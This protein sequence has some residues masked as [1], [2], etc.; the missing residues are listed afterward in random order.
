MVGRRGNTG[1]DTP[2]FRE[3]PVTHTEV[4]FVTTSYQTNPLQQ[5]AETFLS[6]GWSVFPVRHKKPAVGWKR[7]QTQRGTLGELFDRTDFDGIGCVTGPV[8]GGLCV[9]DFDEVAAYNQWAEKHPRLARELPTV[10]TSRGYHVYFRT[11]RPVYAKFEDGE[12]IGDSLHYVVLPPSAHPSGA[13]YEW[14]VEPRGLSD[15]PTLDPVSAGFLPPERKKREIDVDP[16]TE[17]KAVRRS[18]GFVVF[19]KAEKTTD[20]QLLEAA[21]RCQPYETGQRNQK[22]F[23]F[24]RALK[25]LVPDDAPWTTLSQALHTWWNLA[26]RVVATQDYAQTERDFRLAWKSAKVPM[27]Q[28]LAFEVKADSPLLPEAV[29]GGKRDR[30]DTA[31]ERLVRVCQS[32]GQQ[33]LFYLSRRTAGRLIG[34]SDVT[35]ASLLRQFVASGFL[36]IVEQGLPHPTRRR[37]TRY[38]LGGPDVQ[39]RDEDGIRTHS[40]VPGPRRPDR[41]PDGPDQGVRD[42]AVEPRAGRAAGTAPEA[43]PD[44]SAVTTNQEKPSVVVCPLP[45]PGPELVAAEP[46]PTPTR[47]DVNTFLPYPDY[48]RSA[49]CLDWRRLGKQRVECLQMVNCI[50]NNLKPWSNHPCTRMWRPYVQALIEYGVVVCDVWIGRGYNDTCRDK[51]LAFRSGEV[52]TPPW[53]GSPKLHASHRG[54][55]TRKDPAHYS[56]YWSDAPMDTTQYFWPDPKYFWPDH[57]PHPMVLAEDFP[58][59]MSMR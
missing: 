45:T 28:S 43:V 2:V 59:L 10:R 19:S 32:M 36:E 37:A 34:V 22:L 14:V 11:E 16:L 35:A 49:V 8:S 6:W 52:I 31:R 27:S 20:R 53:L 56:Q 25:D 33:G 39:G 9:R 29:L 50:A 4:P 13:V 3:T 42:Q 51:L 1:A 57:E 23:K 40:G 47:P 17:R 46:R 5:E 41:G 30:P 38:R 48:R 26:Q 18:A 15:F 55:L 24:A 7:L 58:C 54:N 21:R 44:V 12:L